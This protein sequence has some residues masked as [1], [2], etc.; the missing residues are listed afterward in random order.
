M[1]H[2]PLHLQFLL[3]PLSCTQESVARKLDT[4]VEKQDRQPLP[5]EQLRNARLGN[6][7]SQQELASHI[8][9]TRLNVS[10]W[11]RGI[12][13]P[14]PYFRHR[15]CTLFGKNVQELGLLQNAST[16][17][18]I[19]HPADHFSHNKKPSD[20]SAQ[21]KEQAHWHLPSRRNLF[22]TGREEVLIR[23]RNAFHARKTA[24]A[25]QV[26][27]LSG[28]GG[29]GKTQIALEYAYRFRDEYSAVLWLRAETHDVLMA[30]VVELAGLLQ[31][32]EKDARD[33]RIT[34]RAVKQWLEHSSSWLLIIDN[35]ED[36]TL[37]ADVLPSQSKGHILLTTRAQA[38]G[39]MA[40]HINVEQMEPDEGALFLLRRAK[41]LAH[42]ALLEEASESCRIQARDIA[43]LLDGLPLALDQAG[44]YI[45]ET[46]C[47]LSSYHTR[48]QGQHAVLL[49][50]QS[51]MNL[52]HPDS[53]SATFSLSFERVEQ[54]SPAAANLLRLC[55]FLHPDD[56]PEEIFTEALLGPDSGG[57]PVVDNL[58]QLDTALIALRKYSLVRRHPERKTL[59][60]HRL[61]QAV[62]KESMDEQTQHH[63]AEQAVC[64]LSRCFPYAHAV[65]MS[66]QCQQL[67]IQAE[68]CIHLIRCW[69][70]I[71]PQAGQLLNHVGVYL[72]ER[73]EY[74]QAE[75]LLNQAR[76][77]HIRALGQDH[78]T[79][80][81]SLDDLAALYGF[82][83]RYSEA[84]P[85]HLQAL[86]IR[87]KQLE[88]NHLDVAR[89]LD[90]LAL[91]FWYQGRYVEAEP[92]F[93]RALGILEQQ[94]GV[95]HPD[96][97]ACLNNLAI[98][99]SRQGRYSEAELFLKRAL[100]INERRANPE[101]L[102]IAR[103][104]NNLALLYRRQGRYSEAEPLFQRGLAILEQQVGL[105]N[106]HVALCL[107]NLAVLYQ[108]Q[109]RF[110]EAEPLFLRA[111]QLRERLLGPDNLHAAHS[112]SHLAALYTEQGKYAEAEALLQRALT[113]QEQQLGLDHPYTADSLHNL[114]E[115]HL[116]LGRFS[117]G[118]LACQQ[119]LVIRDKLLGPEHPCIAQSLHTLAK[120]YSGDGK[121]KEAKSLYHRALGMYEKLLGSQHPDTVKT[122]EH[123]GR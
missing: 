91:T 82:Q 77:I 102:H 44:A 3:S 22:F 47:H 120:L 113:I 60:L 21:E 74:I 6:H 23:L 7:W 67:Y 19:Q 18:A 114:A 17:H 97:A 56:I 63:W 4:L 83:G 107:T 32:P 48:Y 111:L 99:Y 94:A 76:E 90:N 31:L 75:P 101:H 117:Q 1:H 16:D 28:L 8:G 36:F 93:L 109:G 122:R 58:F 43:Q 57:K 123:S 100:A 71:S 26:Y 51:S 95:E 103:D 65:A 5:N 13:F 55:A 2:V 29:I 14:S 112:L 25:T 110:A 39:P 37:L 89:S 52:D 105:E 96:T 49:A 66:S 106:S 62:L 108:L 92:L 9:T 59:S 40:E 69:D 87:E 33:Q 30:D 20:A 12:T 11:E 41:L 15:L 118:E 72:R 24:T 79:V 64:V 88:Q 85:L 73:G 78:L 10:R 54:R 98:L 68:A 46:G 38:T 70:L 81:Q 45:E 86:S 53:V 35:V 104:L 27:A 121:H 119:A 34:L 80:A 61:V 116:A 84:E 50:W 115:L 42:D